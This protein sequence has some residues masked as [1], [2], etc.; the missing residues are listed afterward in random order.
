M[1]KI[2]ILSTQTA[3]LIAAGE[4]VERPSSALKELIENSVDAKATAITVEIRDGGRSYIRVTDN[5]SGIS[6]EDV[7]KALLRHATSKISAGEDLDGV[8][9][10]GFRGEAL[11]AISSVSRL[12]LMTKQ[13]TETTGTLLTADENGIIME[14]TGCPDGTT[15]I[16]RDLF[17]NVPARHKFLKRDVTE[18]G[19]CAGVTERMA[20]SRPDISFTFIANGDRKFFTPGDGDLLTAIYSVYGSE[21]AKGLKQIDYD[22]D[23]SNIKGFVTT[24]DN[25]RGSRALQVF[26]VNN[27]A[28]RS[29]TMTAALEE[30][31]RSYLPRGRFPVGVLKITINPKSTDVNIHPAK[32]EI[33]FSN[34]KKIFELVYYSVKSMLSGKEHKSKT[35]KPEHKQETATKG[36][37]QHSGPHF[38]ERQKS[39]YSTQA[40]PLTPRNEKGEVIGYEVFKPNIGE[41]DLPLI[42]LKTET[43]MTFKSSDT[44]DEPFEKQDSEQVFV[45]ETLLGTEPAYRI[46]GEAYFTYIFVEKQD[47]VLIIDKHA[48]H[49]R[50]LYEEL[51]GKKEVVM[52]QLLEGI[53]ITVTDY[54]AKTLLEHSDYLK[55]YGFDIDAFG[56]DTLIVRAVP[57]LISDLTDIGPLLEEFA[58]GLADGRALPFEEKCDRMLFTIACKAAMKAGDA[59]PAGHN[60]WLV[61]KLMENPA[62][63]YCPHGRPVIKEFLKKELGRFFDR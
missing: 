60:E 3:N 47:S 22:L 34:D 16:V 4:V 31:F 32:T 13:N 36:N 55:G 50:I 7:P 17:Y 56:R 5:G 15:V 44:P 29:K 38:S 40:P 52:Q 53:P 9:T 24:P 2:N 26:F 43:V 48:A 42:D 11:A 37:T 59:N 54:Q 46:I 14:D 20:L 33:K 25:A 8:L 27:R 63:Q 19:A 61:E 6:R 12:E 10:L 51:T 45:S 39:E 57:S 28:I 23:G 1:G 21:F 49:E 62:V 41:E 35:T 18:G 30:A 58:E